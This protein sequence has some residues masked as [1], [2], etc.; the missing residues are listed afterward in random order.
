VARTTSL[1]PEQTSVGHTESIQALMEVIR[2]RKLTVND[3]IQ[4]ES[5]RQLMALIQDL[6][7]S[8]Q[9]ALYDRRSSPRDIPTFALCGKSCAC[10][11]RIMSPRD[12][13]DYWPLLN[14]FQAVHSTNDRAFASAT[15]DMGKSSPYTAHYVRSC[16]CR[17]P[18]P[19][20]HLVCNGL[21]A[22]FHISTSMP[23]LGTLKT[24]PYWL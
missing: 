14:L 7:F 11:H 9:K 20:P 23:L 6:L 4:R 17:I 8:T 18:H 22:F 1:G 5:H 13:T 16:K 12:R 24:Q 3:M 2:L 21:H 10:L 15:R 19:H